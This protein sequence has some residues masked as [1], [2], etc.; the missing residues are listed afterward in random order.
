MAQ[1]KLKYFIT[2]DPSKFE[3]GMAKAV[4]SAKRGGKTIGLGIAAGTAVGVAGWHISATFEALPPVK[5]KQV[6]TL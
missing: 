2:A 6:M 4:N 1:N 5:F 3:I